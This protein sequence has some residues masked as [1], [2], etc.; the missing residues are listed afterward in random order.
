MQGEFMIRRDGGG[1]SITAGKEH[2]ALLPSPEWAIDAAIAAGQIAARHGVL[3]RVLLQD[4]S[5]DA[6]PVWSTNAQ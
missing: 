4:G 2:Y 6:R 5:G 1:W 3:A